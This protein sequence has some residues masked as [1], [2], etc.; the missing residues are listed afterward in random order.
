MT[1]HQ[2]KFLQAPAPRPRQS[3]LRIR[4]RSWPKAASMRSCRRETVAPA[5]SFGNSYPI[6]AKLLIRCRSQSLALTKQ[7]TTDCPPTCEKPSTPPAARLR[8][9][10]G[11]P[12]LP[13]CK[14]IISG[15]ARMASQ[16]TQALLPPSSR[17]FYLEQQRRSR[18]GAP[19][20][21]Q[22]AQRFSKPSRPAN[23]ELRRSCRENCDRL[24]HDPE[25]VNTGF[26]R[27]KRE[28]FARRSCSHKKR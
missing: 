16:L 28:A 13:G 4:C 11:W 21:D 3:A 20:L 19:D 9:N 14:R 5:A 23:H 22:P 2:V 15:C 6:S 26:P 27:N 18:P 25:K 17:R 24:D 1:R 7:S 12:C 8:L 10:C